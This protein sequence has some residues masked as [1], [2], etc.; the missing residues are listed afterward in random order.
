MNAIYVK[1]PV[2][3]FLHTLGE[4]NVMS[5]GTILLII[6]VRVTRRF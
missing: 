1:D 6:L 2:G 5:L 4:R 3:I